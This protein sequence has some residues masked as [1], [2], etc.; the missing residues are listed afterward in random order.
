[1]PS[2]IST[3]KYLAKYRLNDAMQAVTAPH[4]SKAVAQQRILIDGPGSAGSLVEFARR[5]NSRIPSIKEVIFAIRDPNGRKGFVGS[6][7]WA[8]WGTNEKFTK[9]EYCMIEPSEGRIVTT[10]LETWSMLR[11]GQKAFV[12]GVMELKKGDLVFIELDSGEMGYFG[13]SV[14]SGPG[15]TTITFYTLLEKIG[16][17]LKLLR[18]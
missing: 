7:F 13:L 18:R 4:K 1:M 3:L 6:K 10:S 11:P 14:S 2:G 9:F 17:D 16:R 5:H 12:R 15:N 8:S